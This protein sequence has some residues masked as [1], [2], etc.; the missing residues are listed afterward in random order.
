MRFRS[1]FFFAIV[2]LLAACSGSASAAPAAAAASSPAWRA[3]ALEGAAIA[4]LQHLTAEQVRL[5]RP[6]PPRTVRGSP[7]WPLRA[8]R[9]SD[10]PA[11]RRREWRSRRARDDRSLCELPGQPL[12]PRA[13]SPAAFGHSCVHPS[14][15]LLAEETRT[16]AQDGIDND[17]LLINDC[18]NN[19]MP[20]HWLGDGFCDDGS[21]VKDGGGD[22][23]LIA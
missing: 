19:Q 13:A 9:V 2:G 22:C 1:H 8:A 10:G 23:A 11:R 17:A 7:A 16:A 14:R 5:N 20:H 12:P 18:N 15:A 21:D 3:A 4:R 6:T